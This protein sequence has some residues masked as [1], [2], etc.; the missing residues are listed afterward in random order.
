MSNAF[1][2]NGPFRINPDKTLKI[3]D[4][5]WNTF[6]D[7]LYI[8]QPLGTGYSHVDDINR[9]PKTQEKV[10]EDLYEFFLNFLNE[11]PKYSGRPL[12]FVGQSYAGHYIPYIIPY[13]ISQDNPSLNIKGVAI[14]NGSTDRSIQNK[15]FPEFAYSKGLVSEFKY[16]ISLIGFNYCSFFCKLEWQSYAEYFCQM[17]YQMILGVT[18]KQFSPYDVR[19]PCVNPPWCLNNTLIEEVGGSNAFKKALG[20][21]GR[22]WED[23]NFTVYYAM[24]DDYY[25]SYKEGISSMIRSGLEVIIYYGIEDYICNYKGGYALIQNLEWEGTPHLINSPWRDW[26]EG[27]ELK[28]T[29]QRYQKMTYINVYDA[30][31]MV[32][33]EQPE[34]AL[35]MLWKLIY[36]FD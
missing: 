19:L 11:Y 4:Y 29:Y 13:F 6:S 26:Y 20:V 35:S 36:G 32:S 1:S 24:R 18:E 12:Y 21:E 27:G 10:A 3:H 23:C 34:F 8:D 17:P 30:G 14:G 28:A 16:I 2:E 7:L 15:E 33:T 9:I 31:H 22:P 25:K 5:S